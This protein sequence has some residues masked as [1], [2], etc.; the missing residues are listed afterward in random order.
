LFISPVFKLSL[1][2][3]FVPKH[4]KLILYYIEKFCPAIVIFPL[5]ARLKTRNYN[6]NIYAIITHKEYFCYFFIRFCMFLHKQC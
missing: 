4:N 5:S 2:M 3:P 1:L 6:I